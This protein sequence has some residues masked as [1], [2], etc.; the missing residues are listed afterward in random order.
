MLKHCYK[1]QLNCMTLPIHIVVSTKTLSRMQ[2]STIRKYSPN[3]F[4]HFL[5]QTKSIPEYFVA[6]WRTTLIKSQKP[7]LYFVQLHYY[8][9]NNSEI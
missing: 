8:Y 1:V 6:T 5:P 7:T 2:D 3:S 9:Q 4:K